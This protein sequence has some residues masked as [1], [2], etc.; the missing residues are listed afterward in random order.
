[1]KNLRLFN[2][3]F[4]LILGTLFLFFA[5][6]SD[7]SMPIPKGKYSS[8]VFIINEGN[9]GTDN[10]SI[11]F[12]D[13]EK[14]S[15]SQNIFKL[16]NERPLGNT[17]QSMFIADSLAYVV[18]NASNKLEVV[19]YADFASRGSIE[20]GLVNPRYF[21]VVNGKGYITNWG[22]FDGTVPAFIAVIDLNTL[23]IETTIEIGNGL[24]AIMPIGEKLFFTN[25]F[26]NTLGILD[27]ET[28][29]ATEITLH[30]S[31]ASMVEDKHGKLWIIC[32][33]NFGESDGKL[34]RV[35]P[36]TNEVEDSYD[37]GNSA[38][39]MTING[40]G[41]EIFYISGN[42]IYK[43]GI[44]A[45]VAPATPWVANESASF[46]GLGYDNLQNVIYVSDD[47]AFQGSGTVYRYDLEGTLLNSFD[48]GVGP[49]SFV[50]K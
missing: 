24:E 16:V 8:G 4:L 13:R 49:N 25:N 29:E 17:T 6:S 20:E 23:M 42:G 18:V 36:I 40:K 21:T 46:Y 41:D 45:E 26:G 28:N 9:F 31:P 47:N 44:E 43:M 39:K 37:L 33:G 3:L 32:S 1:M 38:S 15:V 5:C 19:N 11:S 34:F 10:S 30:N 48:V 14:D 22:T 2:H 35:N 7:D 27:T 50:F 12:Y